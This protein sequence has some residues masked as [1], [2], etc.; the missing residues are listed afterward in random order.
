MLVHE[1]VAAEFPREATVVPTR[2]IDVTPRGVWRG[3][4]IATATPAVVVA[5]ARAGLL[6]SQVAYDFLNQVLHARGR[7]AGSPGAGAHR[8][9]QGRRHRRRRLRQQDRRARRRRDAAHPRSDGRHRL[10]DLQGHRAVR[11][12][13][14]RAAGQGHR[15]A[16]HHH[17]R[18]PAPRDDASTP[19]SS[20]TRCASTAGCRRPRC[21]RRC[22]ASAGTRSAG[23][24]TTTTSCRAAAASAKS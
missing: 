3:D 9:R 14:L 17:A 1:V 2:M 24:P 7:A 20:S 13:D 11:R 8:R 16:P 12:R 21:C 23:S 6:P 5:V 15:G 10:D 4:A 19:R 22:R 18:V